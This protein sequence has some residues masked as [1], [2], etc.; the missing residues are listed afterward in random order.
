M[1]YISVLILVAGLFGLAFAADY[2]P[3][4]EEDTTAS[5]TRGSIEVNGDVTLA[6][7][8][9]IDNATDGSV[10]VTYDDDAVVLGTEIQESDNAAA[11]IAAG[12][13]FRKEYTAYNDATQKVDYA[14]I[15]VDLTD[16]TDTTED[17]TYEIWVQVNGTLTKIASVDASGVTVV[18][19]VAGTTIGG[20]TQANL[21]D[22]SATETVAGAWTFSNAP[23]LTNGV[24]GT[25][26]NSIGDVLGIANG[27]ITSITY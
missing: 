27:V 6:N 12:D 18:G 19:D 5:L 24:T 23:N 22:K 20:I 7:D 11:S 15:V 26:T 9:T 17:G 8:E 14:R 4:S 1:K 13:E 2:T 10:R 3:M 16:E 21:L 25:Y